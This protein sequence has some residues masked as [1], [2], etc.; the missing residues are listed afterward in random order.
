MS[1]SAATERTTVG[2][3]RQLI[4]SLDPLAV[5]EE[6]TGYEAEASGVYLTARLET[7]GGRVVRVV[8]GRAGTQVWLGLDAGFSRRIDLGVDVPY[9]AVVGVLTAL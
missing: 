9:I 3:L 1:H 4:L 7:Q 8:H 5:V 6:T 2:P